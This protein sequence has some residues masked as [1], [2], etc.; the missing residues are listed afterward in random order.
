[1]IHVKK[2]FIIILFLF[3]SAFFV[4]PMS[5]N[6]VT[7]NDISSNIYLLDEED[8]DLLDEY[9]HEQTCEG[10]ESLLGDPNDENSV[11][12]LLQ[13]I[14]NYIKI[15]GPIL[16]V[17]LSSIDFAGVVVKGD[18]DAMAKAKKKLTTRL[19]LA[20]SLFFIPLFVEVLLDMF[21]ITGSATCG[22]K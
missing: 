4:F 14:L 5:T 17:V 3:I 11:A 6:A 13:E 21:G 15:I 2:R 9:N 18:D 8:V 22:I 1:V 20:A 12:W 7:I 19:I 16:V 10:G